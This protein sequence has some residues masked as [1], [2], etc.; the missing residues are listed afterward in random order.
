MGCD[1]YWIYINI[2]FY[3]TMTLAIH[4][5][6]FS[7][8][9]TKSFWESQISC[10]CLWIN[11]LSYWNNNTKL[12]PRVWIFSKHLLFVPVTATALFGEV[13]GLFC[14]FHNHHALI[15]G[16]TVGQQFWNQGKKAFFFSFYAQTWAPCCQSAWSLTYNSVKFLLGTH[17]FNHAKTLHS[18]YLCYC[19][20][21]V[22]MS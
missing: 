18:F 5:P 9:F 14:W 13:Q 22:I 19:L 2:T 12:L 15:K 16:S 7:E 8:S 10:L 3:I 6:I 1:Y 17:N 21:D 20:R 4:L 11:V